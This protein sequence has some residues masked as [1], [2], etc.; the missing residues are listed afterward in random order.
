VAGDDTGGVFGADVAELVG[1]GFLNTRVLDALFGDGYFYVRAARLLGYLRESVVRQLESA[2]FGLNNERRAGTVCF[3]TALL[4]TKL[5]II[6]ARNDLLLL[7]CLLY[8]SLRYL[9]IKMLFSP[10]SGNHKNKRKYCAI[11]A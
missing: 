10:L 1:D 2:G 6:T 9:Y 5:L 8:N 11:L 7:R 3:R 4:P